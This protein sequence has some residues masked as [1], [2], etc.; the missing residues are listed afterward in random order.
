MLNVEWCKLCFYND[1]SIDLV[2][3]YFK[4]LLFWLSFYV[5]VL[6]AALRNCSLPTNAD[7]QS[8]QNLNRTKLSSQSQFCQD[9][10]ASCLK[11]GLSLNLICIT[12]FVIFNERQECILEKRSDL[13]SFRVPN[14]LNFRNTYVEYAIFTSSLP[15]I[16]F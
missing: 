3:E 11:I 7:R 15:C 9:N 10:S 2:V 8:R 6:Y 14:I 1:F 13:E 12:S 4:H 5:S 16:I